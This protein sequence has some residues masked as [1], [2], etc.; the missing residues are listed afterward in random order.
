MRFRGRYIERT[1]KYG[2]QYFSTIIIF[3]Y[4]YFWCFIR[5]QSMVC[6]SCLCDYCYNKSSSG[7]ILDDFLY[8]EKAEYSF[9]TL[10]GGII[11]T[12]F[13]MLI[14]GFTVFAYFYQKEVFRLLFVCSM[15]NRWSS[16][17]YC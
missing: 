9:L 11:I 2:K 6:S 16:Y 1:R 4:I 14:I 12:L 8:E 7:G 17:F 3:V 13:S 5:T 10:P 15:M